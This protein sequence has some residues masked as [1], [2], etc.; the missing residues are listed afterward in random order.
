MGDMSFYI[1]CPKG[2]RNFATIIF[3]AEDGEGNLTGTKFV[4][5]ACFECR[6]EEVLEVDVEDCQGS[7]QLPKGGKMP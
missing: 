6:E 3:E 2:H 4:R 5:L 7:H 1:R